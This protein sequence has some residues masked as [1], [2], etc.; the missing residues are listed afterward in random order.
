MAYYVYYRN[1]YFDYP[2]V[3]RVNRRSRD[4]AE[5]DAKAQ[6]QDSPLAQIVHIMPGSEVC[7]ECYHPW[8]KHVSRGCTQITDLQ[9]DDGLHKNACIC[10]RRRPVGH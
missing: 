7:P 6:L 4:S 10:K 8:D 5:I 2:C 3:I 1:N 9:C